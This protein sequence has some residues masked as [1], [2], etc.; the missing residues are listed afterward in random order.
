MRIL[1]DSHV[2]LW[3]TTDDTRLGARAAR[4]IASGANE[5]FLSHASVWEMAIKASL[6]K[7]KLDGP[8][9]RFI[10]EHCELNGIRLLPI[11]FRHVCAV[12]NLPRLHG[13]PFDRLL[14]AQA[15]TEGLTLA[16]K[17]A[18]L[19]SYGVAIL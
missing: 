6:G 2:F 15:L 11:D 9:G 19:K 18:T 7:L 17:D 14:V 4:A 16:S 10:A 12:E 8:V 3:W 1:L 13:D 5:C